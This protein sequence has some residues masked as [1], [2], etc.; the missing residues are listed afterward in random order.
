M[1]R[2]F[3][4]CFISQDDVGNTRKRPAGER[5]GPDATWGSETLNFLCVGSISDPPQSTVPP[6]HTSGTSYHFPGEITC[7]LLLEA[8]G[9]ETA[10]RRNLS[11]FYVFTL[12]RSRS[13]MTLTANPRSP[14]VKRKWNWQQQN[15]YESQQRGGPID[16]QSLEHLESPQREACA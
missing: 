2:D 5:C 16:P 13:I 9:N 15:A 11:S 1:E 3:E 8:D 10:W 6:C 12:S 14:L 4:I 7:C